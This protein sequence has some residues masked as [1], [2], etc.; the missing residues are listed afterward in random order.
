ML[1]S[2]LQRRSDE[3]SICRCDF[4]RHAR[5]TEEMEDQSSVRATA[6]RTKISTGVKAR[7]P[8]TFCRYMVHWT[9]T[10]LHKSDHVASSVLHFT[11]FRV[12]REP[13]ERGPFHWALRRYS[14]PK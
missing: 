13:L 11:A 2:S 10:R 8:V 6:P 14:L 9:C 5:Q 4:E 7:K 12:P 3:S 1:V